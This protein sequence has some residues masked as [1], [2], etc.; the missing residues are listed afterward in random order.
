MPL[1]CWPSTAFRWPPPNSPAP[2]TPLVPQRNGSA[3]PSYS[4]PAEPTSTTRS[5]SAASGWA[6]PTRTVSAPRTPTWQR[7]WGRG[8]LVQKQVPDGVEIALG[9]WR[10]PLL[11]PLV[12]VAAGGSLVELLDDR[13]VALPPV[14]PGNSTPTPRPGSR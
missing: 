8:V 14:E 2:R 9:I 7:A 11:G 1:P 13:A 4:R 10:D 6:W 12:L 3:I 5:T